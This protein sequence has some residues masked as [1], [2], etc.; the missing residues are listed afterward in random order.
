MIPSVVASEVRASIED[1]LKTEFRPASPGFEG[2]MQRFL[3]TP[4]AVFKGPYLSVGLP[5]R[6]GSTGADYFPDVP[7]AFPP[8]RHQEQ[9]F[10]RLKSPYY[11]STL[12][13]T[14]TG[15][16]KTECFMLPILNHC[17][18]HE[19]E[20]GIKALLIYPMNA[21]ATDQAKRL[22]SLIWH[23]PK[24]KGKVTA[25]LF[26]GESERD[27]KAM[28]GEDHIITDKNILRQCPPDILLTN[29]KMLDYLL[30]RPGDQ[31]LWV[32]N[33][34]E[35][36]RYLIVDEIHTFDGAQ[37][38]DLACLIRRLK[39]RL[40]T[41][42]RHLACVGTS[43]TLG[44]SGNKGDMLE[45]ATTVFDE[46]FDENALVEEDRLACGEFLFD[47]YINPLPIPE[48]DKLEILKAANYQTIEEYIRAQYQ[49][50]FEEA[51]SEPFN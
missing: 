35:T 12:V 17:Y 47:A 50:W 33:A 36:L 43:A 38:T 48:P 25:G 1:F 45:Y 8:H 39:A 46:P 24:L 34:P 4:E 42:K 21:L 30:I 19:S 23:N 44:G 51:I 28:M 37:G 22:A 40:Q 2:L 5:F 3:A 14:G 16:G 41:P 9:A 7:M 11:Q 13:A 15:S 32:G 6:P 49:L 20:P 27:P 31:P 26:V 29:Y 10:A 18:Q